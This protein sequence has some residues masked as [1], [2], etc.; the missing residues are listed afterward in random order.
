MAWKVYAASVCGASHLEKGLPC[1]DAFHWIRTPS[2]LLAAV[3]DGAGSARYSALGARQVSHQLLT[4]LAQ[5]PFL[6]DFPEEAITELVVD[7]LNDIR[8]ALARDAQEKQAQLTDF[9]CTLVAVCVFAQHGWLIHLGDGVAAVSTAQGESRVSLPENGEYVNQTWFITSPDWREHLRITPLSGSITQITLMSDGVQPFAMNKG[10]TQLFAPFIDPVVRYL[11]EVP[12]EQ[13][14][15]A[16]RH[17]LSDP[18]IDAITG[19]DKTLLIGLRD[20]DPEY[21]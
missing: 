14:T 3:C 9:A 10:S 13:G 21:G 1:Q 6:T 2:Q 20:D 12:E 5:E 17:T 11:R 7:V 4:R 15:E 8:Q 18:R 16:L 19:D